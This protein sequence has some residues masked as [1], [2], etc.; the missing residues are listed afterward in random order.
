MPQFTLSISEDPDAHGTWVYVITMDE[1]LGAYLHKISEGWPSY[2]AAL[3]N[4]ALMLAHFD[5]QRYVNER[6]NALLPPEE[7]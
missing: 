5:G 7:E 3:D 2:Q 1:G 4:G 6:A